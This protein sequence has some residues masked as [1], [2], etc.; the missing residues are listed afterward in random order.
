MMSGRAWGAMSIT[1]KAYELQM[2]LGAC[3]I[4]LYPAL[5]PH[6]IQDKLRE[7][8]PSDSAYIEKWRQKFAALPVKQFEAVFNEVMNP[9]RV[10]EG[11]DLNA[12]GPR[13]N[14]AW[15]YGAALVD[16]SPPLPTYLRHFEAEGYKPKDAAFMARFLHH[17]VKRL[18][19]PARSEFERSEIGP[20][21]KS[22]RNR[23]WFKF[24]H[25]ELRAQGKA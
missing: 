23:R 9:L 14:P 7:G 22:E 19:E 16:E 3:G 20:G 8:A 6:L 5:I 15:A 21:S 1:E 18:D 24:L 12:F 11:P 4:E 17:M 25:D 2:V 10:N 13:G